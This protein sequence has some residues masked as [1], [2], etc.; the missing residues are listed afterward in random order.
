MGGMMWLMS[1]MSGGKDKEPTVTP[2]PGAGMAV[3][4]S[5]AIPARTAELA[6]SGMTCGS[7]VMHV[8]RKLKEVPG[9]TGAA[10]NLA[11]GR[12]AVT[13]DPAQAKPD[14][15]VHAVE[16]AGYSARV[17]QGNERL[18][19]NSEDRI[20]ALRAELDGVQAQIARLSVADH[21]ESP[22]E[23]VAHEARLPVPT[24]AE[25]PRFGA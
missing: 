23:H 22:S 17:E 19:T 4:P 12:A 11:T 5:L 3:A 9:V 6:V 21:P 18:T 1:R 25:Q 2:S 15:L 14:A 20:A 10:V 24:A 13:Y 16:T 8:E 7:C